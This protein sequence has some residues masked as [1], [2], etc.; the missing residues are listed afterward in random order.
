MIWALA[1]LLLCSQGELLF[2]SAS[3]GFA[4]EGSWLG[5]AQFQQRILF[6]SLFCLRALVQTSKQAVAFRHVYAHDG[7]PWNELADAVHF[8]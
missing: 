4:A 7:Q 3:V 2:D 6:R 8:P 1:C 5:G